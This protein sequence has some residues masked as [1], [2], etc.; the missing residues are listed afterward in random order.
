MRCF[1]VKNHI[2]RILLHVHVKPGQFTL[3]SEIIGDI[4][5]V[6]LFLRID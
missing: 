1:R 5:K 6:H 4:L 3:E 2:M